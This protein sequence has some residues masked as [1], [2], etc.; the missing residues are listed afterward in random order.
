MGVPFEYKLTPNRILRGTVYP[1]RRETKGIL[2]VC[3]GYK[4]F[5]DWGFFPYI[6]QKLSERYHVITF[7]F[8][9]NGIGEDLLEFTELE[10]FAGNTYS[11]EQEDLSVLI[12]AIRRG[13][14]PLGDTG[15][16]SVYLLGHSRGAGDCLIYALDHPDEIAGVVSWNG[17]TNVDLFSDKEKAEMKE[18]GRTYILNGRTKQQMPLNREILDDLE[19]NAERFNILGRISELQPPAVLI[20]GKD[21]GERLR[22]GSAALTQLR[23]DIPWLQVPGGNHTFGAVHPFQGTTA[24]LEEAIRL[25]LGWL[26]EQEE[27][28]E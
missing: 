25:T 4:G 26:K 13:E 16:L 19:A 17:V 24:A 23:P 14:T 18:R 6:G 7:N 3:H 12:G 5:K 28:N 10:K 20:Q 21:D 15:G 1:S 9:H 2:V 8:T 27:R 11:R 22:K